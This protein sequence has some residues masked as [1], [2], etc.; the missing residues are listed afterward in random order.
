MKQ[1]MPGWE[2]SLTVGVLFLTFSL[3]LFDI[4]PSGWVV[5][6]TALGFFVLSTLFLLKVLWDVVI[7]T[8]AVVRS[9][10]ASALAQGSGVASSR[11]P[12]QRIW[13]GLRPAMLLAFFLGYW[14]ALGRGTAQME[15][16]SLE[17]SVVVVGIIWLFLF[18]LAIPAVSLAVAFPQKMNSTARVFIAA[19]SLA[20]VF[21]GI[22]V[23]STAG[24]QNFL[25]GIYLV[26]FGLAI[27]IA[28]CVRSTL[29]RYSPF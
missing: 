11:T 26:L 9:K 24:H 4:S 12:G 20:L 6:D 19:I 2:K 5:R 17:S 18:F 25:S 23:A 14:L 3:T 21:C 16:K 29:A 8:V 28:V 15:R 1:K 10:P 13:E 22:V 27:P 7:A